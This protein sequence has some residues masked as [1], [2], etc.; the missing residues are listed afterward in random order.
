MRDTVVLRHRYACRLEPHPRRFQIDDAESRVRFAL[1][2]EW[3]LDAHMDGNARAAEPTASAPYQ[4]RWFGYFMQTQQF[5]IESARLCFTPRRH[6]K[7]DVVNTGD[8][9]ELGRTLR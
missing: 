9:H 6:S 2:R 3:F 7:L 1:W 4:T 8:V 5:T